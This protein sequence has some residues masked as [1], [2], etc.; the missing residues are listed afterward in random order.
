MDESE[1]NLDNRSDVRLDD[2]DGKAWRD[3]EGET[4]KEVS[5]MFEVYN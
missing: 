3:S 2:R 5:A 4:E 1:E